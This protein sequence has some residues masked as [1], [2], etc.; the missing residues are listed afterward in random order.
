MQ[1]NG[2]TIEVEHIGIRNLET[3]KVDSIRISTRPDYI[4]KNIQ[5]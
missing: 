5:F 3:G 1:L 4:N 2:A